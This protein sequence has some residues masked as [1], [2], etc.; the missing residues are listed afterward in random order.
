LC[1]IDCK[2]HNICVLRFKKKMIHNFTAFGFKKENIFVIF[3]QKNFHYKEAAKDHKLIS[4]TK[5]A[6][7]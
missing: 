3:A 1:K 6:V 7:F 5:I 2:R 4:F